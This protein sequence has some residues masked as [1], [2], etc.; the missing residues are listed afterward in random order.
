MKKLTLLL[1][2]AGLFST[3]VYANGHNMNYHMDDGKMVNHPHE[4]F[5][6]HDVNEKMMMNDKEDKMKKN[7]PK[8]D[9]LIDWTKNSTPYSG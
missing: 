2:I 3:M 7:N 8:I 4:D 6:Q 9:T 5:Y 1:F